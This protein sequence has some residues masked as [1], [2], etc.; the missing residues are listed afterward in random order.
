[1][2]REIPRSEKIKSLRKKWVSVGITL[3][4]LAGI[5]VTFVVIA[6]GNDIRQSDI[7]TGKAESGRIESCIVATGKIVPLSEQTVVSP[8]STKILEVYCN[9]GDDIE[10]GEPM[11]SLD[12]AAAHIDMQRAED[13]MS[14]KRNEIEQTTLG[15][16]T[17]LTDMEMKIKTKR[18][19]VDHLKAEVENE[20]R[21]DSIG[22]GTGDRIRKA[23]LEYETA[24]LELHQMEM[25]LTNERKSAEASL[26][27]KRLER[28]ISERNFQSLLHTL[29]DA[30][31]RSPCKGTVTFLNKNIGVAI[32]V[33]EKL[34]VISDLSHFRVNCSVS[35]GDAIKISAGSEVHVRIG[36]NKITGKVNG[37]S[38]Q[39]KNGMVEFS[40]ILENDS[41][42]ALRS[43][44]KAEINVVYDILDNVVRIPNGSYY[45][46][47]GG[48][49]MFVKTDDNTLERRRVTL[50]DCNF[51]Y[52]EVKS[53]ISPGEEV[54]ISD[55]SAYKNYKKIT[56]KN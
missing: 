2:D 37:I 50:G 42:S 56:I 49:T 15:N 46:G 34:A 18:M 26:R 7:K 36:R 55:M 22:S 24:C 16:H 12:L 47:A 52:V 40:V 41:H 23:Q 45:Q 17:R 5:I 53:G 20:K 25:Q 28:D 29:E 14:M 48:Y 6:G 39:S 21:L 3:V 10:S 4:L 11:L 33:G 8:V 54:V 9:E 43:G 1:M 35:E 30:K 27:S 51:D 19:S 32:V 31:L 38:P 13:E 44:L